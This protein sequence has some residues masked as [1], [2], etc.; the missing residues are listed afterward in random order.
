M[1]SANFAYNEFEDEE[2]KTNPGDIILKC[3]IEVL[4][5][6]GTGIGAG[7]FAFFFKKA[8]RIIKAIKS[9]IFVCGL[10]ALHYIYHWFTG[11]FLC[12]IIYGFVIMKIWGHDHEKGVPMH[13]I[14]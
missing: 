3:F 8:P 13:E 5:G 9:A 2:N 11:E 4:I 12:A 1:V 7:L 14:E 10:V 6:T